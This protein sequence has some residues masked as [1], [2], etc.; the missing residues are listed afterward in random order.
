MFLNF[1]DA[2]VHDEPIVPTVRQ[3]FENMLVVLLR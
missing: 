1:H 2:V 3:S